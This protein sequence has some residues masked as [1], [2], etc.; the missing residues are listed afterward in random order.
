M[1]SMIL[2]TGT[3]ISDSIYLS[4]PKITLED[5]LFEES[6]KKIVEIAI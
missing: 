6:K 3:Q 1:F 2:K 5:E 4:D